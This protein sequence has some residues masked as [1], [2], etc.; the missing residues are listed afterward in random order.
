[1]GMDGG[2]YPSYQPAPGASGKAIAALVLGIL[3]FCCCNLL[4]PVAWFLG[5]A[6]RKAIR[7]G[8]SAAAGDGL[9][10]GG[11]ILGIIGTILLVIGVIGTIVWLVAAG[12]LAVI[13]Q[14]ANS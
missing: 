1:M 13:S 4:G 6:E 10:L 12:G 3:S 2:P 7:D 9:A 5:A 11:M 8:Q 14:L